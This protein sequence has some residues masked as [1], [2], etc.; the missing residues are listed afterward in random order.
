[1]LRHTSF[2]IVS[3]AFLT[4]GS[5]F[6]QD[7]GTDAPAT[8]GGTAGFDL[9]QPVEQGPRL[10]DRYN[11]ESFGDWDLACIKTD[12]ETDPCSLLQILRDEEGNPVAEVSL[13][14]I[15]GGGEAAT[16]GTIIVPLETLLPAQLGISVDGAPGRLY[17]YSF[18]NPVG[19]VAQVGFTQDDI[20][21]FKRGR[22]ATI[23]IVAAARPDRPIQL[24]MSLSGFTAGY[25]VVDIVE[26]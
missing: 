23:S 8:E 4:A 22:E 19:C 16:G 24:G 21:G 25:D 17:N 6:A 26:N 10:G 5:A 13:F 2:T 20:D 12:A 9:G 15:S 11:K 18:C 3:A 7:T 14:R 1:M